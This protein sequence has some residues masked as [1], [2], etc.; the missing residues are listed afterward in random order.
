MG[1]F[2]KLKPRTN[3]KEKN[4]EERSFRIVS[5]NME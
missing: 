4:S 3:F 1:Y 5:K 2:Y